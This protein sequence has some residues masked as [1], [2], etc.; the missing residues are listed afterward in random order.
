MEEMRFSDYRIVNV[1]LG[2]WLF[3]SAFLWPHATAEMINAA[4]VGA[5]IVV[6]GSVG[7]KWPNLRFLNAALAVWLFASAYLLP[8]L[9]WGTGANSGLVA[10]SV[11]LVSLIGRYGH[12][13]NTP[14]TH[15][16]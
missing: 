16:T 10:I 1:A 5:A 13:T 7:T 3:V 14:A 15:G 2:A 6:I 4:L 9:A 11:F 8:T 12:E